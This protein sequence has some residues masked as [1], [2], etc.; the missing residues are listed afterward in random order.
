MRAYYDSARTVLEARVA[1]QPDEARF[2]SELGLAYAGLGRARDA[3]E[4]GQRAVELLPTS[5][6]ALFGADWARNLAQIYTMVGDYDAAVDELENL[7]SINAA[8][9]GHWLQLD[10]IWGPL[11]SNSR[12]RALIDRYPG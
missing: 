1:A 4:A 3:I 7:L 9:C 11:H 12:F 5:K 8:I 6:E 2:H 10:P